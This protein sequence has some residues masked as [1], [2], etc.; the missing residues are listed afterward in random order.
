V[1]SSNS[2]DCPAGRREGGNIMMLRDHEDDVHS[3]DVDDQDGG[4]EDKHV[5]RIQSPCKRRDTM[6]CSK[7]QPLRGTRI[8]TNFWKRQP[9]SEQ[10][11]EG[12]NVR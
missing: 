6:H 7:N 2:G 10:N 8:T 12:L 4:H 1:I 11:S 3:E 9:M 5:G